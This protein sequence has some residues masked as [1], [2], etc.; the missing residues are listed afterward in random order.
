MYLL[1]GR[2][3]YIS[4]ARVFLLFVDE[5]SIIKADKIVMIRVVTFVA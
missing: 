5:S 3:V 2:F 4:R 1:A